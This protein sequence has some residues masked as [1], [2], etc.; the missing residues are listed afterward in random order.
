MMSLFIKDLFEY[1]NEDDF[2]DNIFIRKK[3]IN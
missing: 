3:I 1:L 2:S